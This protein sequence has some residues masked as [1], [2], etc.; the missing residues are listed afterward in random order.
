[1]SVCLCVIFSFP[2]EN[3]QKAQLENL[4]GDREKIMSLILG[5]THCDTDDD[6]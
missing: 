4:L 6:G 2:L 1:M 3:I 5:K